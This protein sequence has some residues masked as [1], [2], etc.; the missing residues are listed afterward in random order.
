MDIPYWNL[1]S[2][3]LILAGINFRMELI[4]ANWPNSRKLNPVKSKNSHS[5]KLIPAKC[6]K[7]GQIGIKMPK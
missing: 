4:F 2:R 5:R 7:F 6:R 1:F 3:E